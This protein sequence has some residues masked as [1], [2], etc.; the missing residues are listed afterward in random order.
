MRLHAL[1]VA[2]AVLGPLMAGC[3]GSGS[4][5]P[6]ATTAPEVRAFLS[7][8]SMSSE[9]AGD[10][11]AAAEATFQD[12]V[13]ET[14][15][16]LA[17]RLGSTDRATAAAVLEAT[18]RVEADLVETTPDP[19]RLSEDVAGLVT[20]MGDALAAAGFEAPPCPEASP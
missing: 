5:S 14:L 7:L 20:A 15:H 2:T 18:S 3:G 19:A 11:V 4:T 8:C 12:E 9:V 10:D 1:V 6:S 17:D 16:E 13:H